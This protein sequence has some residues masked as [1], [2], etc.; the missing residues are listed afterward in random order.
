MKQIIEIA[1][2]SRKMILKIVENHTLDQLNKIPEGHKNNLIWNLGHLLVTQQLLVYKLSGLPMAVSESMVEKYRKGT[3]PKEDATQ[4]EVDEIKAL[5]LPLLAKNND[6]FESG[7]F[8]N[9]QEYPT[10]TGFILQSVEDAIHFNNFHE[11]IHL[12]IILGL[13]KLV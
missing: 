3:D 6:D 1:I 2:A 8:K 10:S 5:F 13:R 12:G 7:M 9:F 11:G 4:E